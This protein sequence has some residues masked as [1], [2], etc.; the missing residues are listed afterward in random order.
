MEFRQA[1]LSAIAIGIG[2]ASSAQ[3]DDIFALAREL[4]DAAPPYAR[5]T[6]FSLA[7]KAENAALREA[8]D[9]LGCDIV[10]LDEAEF[11]ARQPEFLARGAKASDIAREKTG[12]ASV[13]EAAA[14]MGGGPNAILIAPRRAKNNVTCALAAP[15][16][17]LKT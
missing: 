7:R 6:V 9:R 3:A 15:A 8:A 4:L 17:E 10:L 12:F 13:A 1:M 14:L 2:A 16:D 5:A 11:S